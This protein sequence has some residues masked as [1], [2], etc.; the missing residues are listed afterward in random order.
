[1][2]YILGIIHTARLEDTSKTYASLDLDPDRDAWSP[3]SVD[4]IMRVFKKTMHAGVNSL[5][6]VDAEYTERHGMIWLPRIYPDTEEGER[7][8]AVLEDV[9]VTVLLSARTRARDAC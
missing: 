9:G 3:E 5:V 2:P 6:H 1:M 8:L 7:Q 4:A